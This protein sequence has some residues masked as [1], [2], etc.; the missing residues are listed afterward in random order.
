MAKK[1]DHG[2]WTD[3]QAGAEIENP[4]ASAAL[5][6][7]RARWAVKIGDHECASA[8]VGGLLALVAP[9]AGSDAPTRIMRGGL[10]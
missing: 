3:L 7:D 9:T 8:H 2:E 5:K 10:Q 4:K 6:V 1:A